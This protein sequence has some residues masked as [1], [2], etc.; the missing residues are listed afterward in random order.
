MIIRV[1]KLL[2]NVGA[3]RQRER[4]VVERDGALGP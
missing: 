1:P 4:M 3:L 2:Q